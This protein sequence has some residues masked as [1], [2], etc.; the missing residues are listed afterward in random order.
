[1]ISLC[2]AGGVCAAINEN[3]LAACRI[4]DQLRP[5]SPPRSMYNPL[6][7]GLGS[8]GFNSN[9]ATNHTH[10]N[11][12]QHT[13]RTPSISIPCRIHRVP[14]GCAKHFASLLFDPA[15]V[16][17]RVCVRRRLRPSVWLLHTSCDAGSA[18]AAHLRRV[19][20]VSVWYSL[21]LFARCRLL[22]LCGCVF[23]VFF[24]P[25]GVPS[26]CAA[27]ESRHTMQGNV[28]TAERYLDDWGDQLF[29]YTFTGLSLC[30]TYMCSAAVLLRV[31]VRY[32]YVFEPAILPPLPPLLRYKSLPSAVWAGVYA[33]GRALSMVTA[34]CVCTAVCT[35]LSPCVA[36]TCVARQYSCV[37]ASVGYTYKYSSNL[38]YYLTFLQRSCGTNS[39]HHL[40]MQVCTRHC[41]YA[42]HSAWSQQCMYS[43]VR[44]V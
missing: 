28:A 35:Q 33:A 18:V 21:S 5:K 32:A 31:C 43:G 2:G 12:H 24:K 19:L 39:F 7:C 42:A 10:A 15:S 17:C 20:W 11:A 36:H 29:Q 14:Q 3:W 23:F 1:M 38:P 13:Q 27:A 9:G 30:G 41:L 37:L 25:Y 6:C 4:K 44:T 40:C 8:F 34:V 26:P 22:L 16:I